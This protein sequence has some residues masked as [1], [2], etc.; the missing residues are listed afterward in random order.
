MPF[1]MLDE[2]DSD[3]TTHPSAALH[4]KSMYVF[5]PRESSDKGPVVVLGPARGGTSM[6]AGALWHL[7]FHLGTNVGPPVF[8]SN[9]MSTLFL[10]GSST[11]IKDTVVKLN[12]T[13]EHWAWKRPSA[14][15]NLDEILTLLEPRAL[16]FVFRDPLATAVRRTLALDPSDSLSSEVF[17]EN[18]NEVIDDLG[19]M[20]LAFNKS[21]LPSA[22][23]S[24]ETALQNP[25]EF[26]ELLVTFLGIACTD[27]QRE[28]AVAFIEPSPHEYLSLT[29]VG[30][31]KGFLDEADRHIASGWAT[32]ID[33]TQHV[34]VNIYVDDELLTSVTANQ[35]RSDLA[36][37]GLGDCAFRIEFDS[38]IAPG[39]RL[40]ARVAGDIVDLANSPQIV[41]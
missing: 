17:Q 27:L 15:G 39:S 16:L 21:E 4:R 36:E 25:V 35:P 1:L 23:I 9:E 40:R 20:R 10:E 8:E 2:Y 29:R 6:V 33:S 34:V 13:H 11:E 32:G 12:N 38:P 18:F 22:L 31:Y 41:V 19:R 24:Y 26:V 5:N 28:S 37:L 30:G 14:L 7:G 3:M